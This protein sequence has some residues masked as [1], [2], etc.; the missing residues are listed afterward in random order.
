VEQLWQIVQICQLEGDRIM[1]KC[2]KCNDL[3]EYVYYGAR[4]GEEIPLCNH[5]LDIALENHFG[6]IEEIEE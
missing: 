2:S 4:G 3:A 5:H 6:N 1:T